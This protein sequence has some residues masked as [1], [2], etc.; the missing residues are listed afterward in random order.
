VHRALA[1]LLV[2]ACVRHGNLEQMPQV[3]PNPFRVAVQWQP[4]A[5][6]YA[7]ATLS[8][9]PWLEPVGHEV[10]IDAGCDEVWLIAFPWPREL[11]STNG[12]EVLGHGA[13]MIVEQGHGARMRGSGWYVSASRESSTGLLVRLPSTCGVEPTHERLEVETVTSE[14][15]LGARARHGDRAIEVFPGAAPAEIT[16]PV[17]PR[18]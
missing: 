1:L 11:P 3:E 14:L 8:T 18:P 16:P 15:G 5:G 13:F 7:W 6:T 10:A 2:A 12:F 9:E 4:D 17:A